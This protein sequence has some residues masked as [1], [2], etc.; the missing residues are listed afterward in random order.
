MIP[1]GK[2]IRFENGK[3]SYALLGLLLVG[4]W[5]GILLVYW[6][7]NWSRSKLGWYGLV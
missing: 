2:E 7:W 3:F 1:N 6:R 4:K 5:E